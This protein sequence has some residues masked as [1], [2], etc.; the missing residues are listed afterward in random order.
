M[1]H[2][3]YL[4]T[5]FP[6]IHEAAVKAEEMALSDPRASAFYGRRAV[7]LAVN[8]AYKHD[9]NLLLPYQDNLMALIHEPS[10]IDLVGQSILTKAK[11]VIRLGN[12][13]VNSEKV[14]GQHDSVSSLRELTHISYW[15]VRTYSASGVPKAPTFDQNNLPKPIASLVKQTI[16]KLKAQQEELS[17][18]DEKLSLVL[19]DKNQLNGE[20]KALRE[21][22]AKAKAANVNVAETHDYNEEETRDYFIDLLL[23]EAG[24]PLDQKRDREYEVQ[25]MPNTSGN[26][27]V[28]YVLW[29]SDGKPLAVIEAKRTKRDAKV[30][31]NQ[32]KLYADCLETESGQRPI[33]FYTNGYDHHLWDDCMHPPRPV[34]GFLK[35]DELE[36]MIQRR[37]SRQ[38][39]NADDANKLIAGRPYQISAIQRVCESFQDEN[40]RKGLLVMAT[41]S[42]KTRTVIALADLLMQMNWAKRILFLADRVAL[43]KQAARAFK[44]HL[45]SASIVN[46]TKDKNDDGRVYV[47]TYPTMMGLID[48]KTSGSRKFGVGHFDLIII[49][50]AHRSVYQKYRA[51]FDYFDSYL[52]GL[53]ATPVEEIDRNTYSLFDLEE[54]VPTDAYTLDEAIKEGY[55]VPPVPIS[56]PLKFQREGIKY[57]DLSDEEKDEWDALEWSEDGE[58]PDEV[59]ADAVNRWLFNEDTVDKMIANLMTDGIKVAGGDKLG[60]TIIF[61]K[62]QR[63]ADFIQERFD[64]NYPAYKGAFSRVI[65]FKTEYAQNLIDAFS[66]AD[67]DPQI[68]ISVDML[69]TGI[70]VPEVVNLVIFKL[71]RSKT[72]FWQILGRGTRLCPNLFGPGEDKT[73]F[74]VFDYCQNL[75][76]FSQDEEQKE[77]TVSISLSQRLFQLKLELIQA[78][79]EKE[80]SQI[81]EILRDDDF[82]L[83]TESKIRE[84]TVDG[85]RGIVQQMSLDN[86]IVRGKRIYVEKYQDPEPWKDI[87]VIMIGEVVEHIANLPSAMTDSDEMAKRFDVLCLNLQLCLLRADKGFENYSA[88]VVRIAEALIDRQEVPAINLQLPLLLRVTEGDYW[89]YISVPM[90]E[91]MRVRLRPLIKLIDSSSREIVYTNFEDELGTS[92]IVNLTDASEKSLLKFRQKAKVYLQSHLSHISLNK[93]RMNK[94][95]TK[96]DLQELEKMFLESGVADE[97]QIQRASDQN[98]GLGLFIRSLVGLDKG[99]A[100]EVFSEFIEGKKLSA[101]QHEFISM[102]IDYLVERGVVPPEALYQS[103]F[104]NI[105]PQGP[106]SIFKDEEVAQI[107]ELL[108]LVESHATL[109]VAS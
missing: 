103:P 59:S 62:N 35:Q 98:N 2:F 16:S 7:D 64:K 31:Q 22:V 72:K 12:Q 108:D 80:F 79:D 71:I 91:V 102:V 73:E 54:G 36:L 46:L 66:I 88:Q 104:I 67:K 49:D 51:I 26:G 43:V 97:D 57:G 106:D 1:S 84:A 105:A 23:K 34:Q 5:E 50:E 25:G 78:I 86:F 39:L 68:A 11:I 85:L 56:V 37:T 14:I 95:L 65:T 60:K 55:L 40:H 3:A 32:A 107:I 44:L 61:A 24:W 74:Y 109:M 10:F 6:A 9:K 20:L 81:D 15:L 28:D 89:T 33:I 93:L 96:M 101:N 100:Q 94:P 52:L 13:A 92:T 99:A 48:G 76:Y 42:G 90:I 45:P 69:D 38:K 21:E 82:D 29:G 58:K 77:P 17:A 87:D 27:F 63:H 70:D 4:Q 30:G 75:E 41:G 53:T 18:K 8:W 83:P 47:S 19:A